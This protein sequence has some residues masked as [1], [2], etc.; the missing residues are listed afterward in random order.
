MPSVVSHQLVVAL[1]E[2]GRINVLPEEEE[3]LIIK[4]KGIRKIECD[5]HLSESSIW[6]SSLVRVS[7]YSWDML[8]SLKTFM[9]NSC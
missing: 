8:R 6:S 3:Y 4:I 5:I 9:K 2:R 1:T 7:E